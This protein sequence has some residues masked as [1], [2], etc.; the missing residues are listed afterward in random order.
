MV[1]SL[2]GDHDCRRSGCGV[3]F[4]IDIEISATVQVLIPD[5]NVRLWLGRGAIKSN[6]VRIEVDGRVCDI[7]VIRAISVIAL[8]NIGVSC[9]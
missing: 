7:L 6:I 1:L 3:V 9:E 5:V 8:L 2:A 4:V